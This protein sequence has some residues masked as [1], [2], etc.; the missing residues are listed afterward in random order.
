MNHIMS[1][2][3]LFTYNTG[4]KGFFP[5]S[6]SV[7]TASS[8]ERAVHPTPGTLTVPQKFRSRTALLKDMLSLVRKGTLQKAVAATHVKPPGFQLGLVSC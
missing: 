7:S 8:G 3:C 2:P 1:H 5:R 4:K 6:K